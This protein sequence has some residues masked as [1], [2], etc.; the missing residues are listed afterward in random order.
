[1]DFDRRGFIQPP[2]RHI[3]DLN[4]LESEFVTA[5]PNS[6]TRAILFGGYKEYTEDFKTKIAEEFIQWIG[7]SFTTK[8]ENPRDIDLVTLVDFEVYEAKKELIDK[9]F[10]FKTALER[11]G[12]DGYAVPIYPEDHSKYILT[13]GPLIYWDQQFSKSRPNRAKKTFKRGYVE[14]IFKVNMI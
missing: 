3:F 5:F 12:V 1:M 14:I 7:G 6:N 11:Y 8:K 10:R 2:Q 13:K 4:E 9:E